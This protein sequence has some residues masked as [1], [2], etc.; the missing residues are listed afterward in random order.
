MES[1]QVDVFRVIVYGRTVGAVNYRNRGGSTA[2]D[3]KGTDLMPSITGHAKIDGK[4]GRLVIDADLDHV[5]PTSAVG[6]QYLTY[7]LWAV[8]PE[9][10]AVNL[11]EVL[12]NG[13]GRDKLT[14]TTD[15]QAFG[16]IVRSEERRVGKECRSR[17]SP[18]HLK[19]KK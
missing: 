4:A 2:V 8:T 19:K 14:V 10:R 16:L 18:Y 1:S 15:L 7:V 3:F 17:W 11:G 6:P 9:G 12:P 5:G 13:N